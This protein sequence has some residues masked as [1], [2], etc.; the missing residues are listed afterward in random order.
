MF[1]VKFNGQNRAYNCIDVMKNIETSNK[2]IV[3]N[4]I[5]INS[6]FIEKN[7]DK[8]YFYYNKKGLIKNELTKE[9]F[10]IMLRI[11]F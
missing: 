5:S 10:E 1:L 11:I 2:M 3:D 8:S 9:N 7:K 4:F 6:I